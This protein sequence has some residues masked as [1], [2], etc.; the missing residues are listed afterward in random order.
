MYFCGSAQMV[1]YFISQCVIV[2]HVLKTRGNKIVT[3]TFVLSIDSAKLVIIVNCY[4]A[5]YLLYDSLQSVVRNF[6]LVFIV[7]IFLTFL[8]VRSV[9]ASPCSDSFIIRQLM[10]Y[11]NYTYVQTKSFC[12]LMVLEALNAVF[13]VADWQHKTQHWLVRRNNF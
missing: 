2:Y 7:L 10:P 8:S 9:D 11:L 3:T 6:S 4:S 12:I 5:W 13:Y 1:K